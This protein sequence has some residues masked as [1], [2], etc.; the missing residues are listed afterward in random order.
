MAVAAAHYLELLDR[1]GYRVDGESEGRGHEG[2][3]DI[4]S[5]N[6]DVSDKSAAKT[7]ASTNVAGRGVA[8]TSAKASAGSTEEVGI[9]PSLFTFTKPVDCA[10][11]V[12]MKAM[13]GGELLQRATF[14][15]LEEMEEVKNPFHLRVLLEKVTVV[16]YRLGG[17]AGEFRVDLDETWELNYTTI[18]FD[19]VSAG[20]MSASFPRS[21]G[22]T[23]RAASKSEP[24][25]K[26]VLK[27][28]L[29]LRQALGAKATNTKDKRG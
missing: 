3:I 8:A 25:I 16:S 29:E 13:N 19:Y 23:K 5:W 27:D 10:T 26:Q 9:D 28:N 14:E 20:G 15:L 1:E 4:T 11:T 18:S 7:G 22:S 12:L 24:D 17:R 21:P 2:Q 6:W